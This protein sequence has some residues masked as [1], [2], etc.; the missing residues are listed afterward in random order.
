MAHLR[1]LVFLTLLLSTATLA[2]VA[3]RQGTPEEVNEPT[4]FKSPMIVDLALPI[5]NE[6]LW[7]GNQIRQQNGTTLRDYIC[8]GIRFLDFATSAKKMRNGKVKVIFYFTLFN[9]PGMDKLA[10][11][12][13]SIKNGDAVVGKANV[14]DM[15][16]EEKRQLTKQ[17]VVEVAP[18]DLTTGSPTLTISLSVK[19]NP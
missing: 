13:F 3:A 18:E 17:V 6:A 5:A 11:L 2:Q 8:D 16:I 12:R 1:K 10:T 19:D 9:E 14:V 7:S 4:R 15:D